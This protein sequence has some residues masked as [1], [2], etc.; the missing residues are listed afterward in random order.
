MERGE[1]KK[2]NKTM[3]TAA[4]VPFI[5]VDTVILYTLWHVSHGFLFICCW[6]N[7]SKAPFRQQRKRV[8]EAGFETEERAMERTYLCMSKERE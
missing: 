3:D 8:G 4:S 5:T 2:E 1:E 7:F 6:L